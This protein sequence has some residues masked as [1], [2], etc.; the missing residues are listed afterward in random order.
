MNAV[1]ADA[2][3]WIALFNPRDRLH[4]IATAVSRAIQN[5]SI[6]TS[7]LVLMEFLNYYASLG[8]IFRQQAVEVVRNLQQYPNV[9]IVPLSD[10]QFEAALTM[11]AQR[12]DKTWGLID[13]ASFLI[14]QQ[15]RIT[16]VLA[17]DEHFRQ[18]GFIPLL[19]EN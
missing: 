11:Y 14:M 6:V 17:Y 3:Y 15:R 2:G 1:F 16:E 10:E 9:E 19:R 18:A 12:Q 7:Q 8:Q 13:C 4:D 5:R